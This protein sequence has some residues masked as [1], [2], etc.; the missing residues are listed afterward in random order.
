MNCP[1]CEAILPND[2]RECT[3]CGAV[4]P[5]R[6]SSQV[7][8]I[9]DDAAQ[10]VHDVVKVVR[11][12]Q[13]IGDEV[14]EAAHAV[15]KQAKTAK[16]GAGK[17]WDATK[18][19]VTDEARKGRTAARHLPPKAKREAQHLRSKGKSAEHAISE[20]AHRGRNKMRTATLRVAPKSPTRRRSS[21]K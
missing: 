19:L 20:A 7:D 12:V 17:V 3:A 2:A 8:R 16:P 4:L 18:A 9:V 14:A 5:N 15:S 13:K 6:S 10:T 21:S 11:S 1:E